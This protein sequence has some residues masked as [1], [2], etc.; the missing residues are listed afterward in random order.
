MKKSKP[1]NNLE[2]IEL[3]DGNIKEIKVDFITRKAEIFL[4]IYGTPFYEMKEKEER[5]SAIL[6]FNDLIEI[7]QIYDAGSLSENHFAGNINHWRMNSDETLVHI[8]LTDGY[9]KVASGSVEIALGSDD[10]AALNPGPPSS[11]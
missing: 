6:T 3:H 9:I 10:N 8:Y 11:P 5:I 1:K 2:K 4:D 7:S